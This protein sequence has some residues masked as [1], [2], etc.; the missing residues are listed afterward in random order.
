MSRYTLRIDAARCKGCG[1]CVEFC[2]RG[3]M[4][5]SADI[6]PMGTHPAEVCDETAC[7]GCKLC[8]LMCPDVAIAIYRRAEE[9]ARTT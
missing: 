6:T 2:P 1:L 4:R 9:E 3:N 8:V 7:S 5:I